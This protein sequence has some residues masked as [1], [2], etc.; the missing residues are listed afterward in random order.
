MV[1]TGVT[2]TCQSYNNPDKTFTE[3]A[4]YM[5]KWQN[6]SPQYNHVLI[7]GHGVLL[8]SQTNWLRE[9]RLESVRYLHTFRYNDRVNKR[10]ISHQ[11]SA[12]F[13]MV[14]HDMISIV[15]FEL[16]DFGTVN[17]N[18]GMIRARVKNLSCYTVLL[19][20]CVRKPAHLVSTGIR[21]QL[22]INQCINQKSY[23][24]IY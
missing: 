17:I 23:N 1:V 10:E 12:L 20:Q 4:K 3:G 2:T 21:G 13:K 14:H 24:L 15:V 19:V 9:Q 16:I 22:Y 5:P 6:Q 18:H 7:Q 8:G 11:G